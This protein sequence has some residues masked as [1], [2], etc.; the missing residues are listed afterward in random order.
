MIGTDIDLASVSMYAEYALEHGFAVMLAV[1]ARKPPEG[2][3]ITPMGATHK[4][5]NILCL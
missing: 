1:E 4:V 3:R 2:L 5:I